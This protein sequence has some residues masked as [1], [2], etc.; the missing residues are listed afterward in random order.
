MANQPLFFP[1]GGTHHGSCFLARHGEVLQIP[2]PPVPPAVPRHLQDSAGEPVPTSALTL[3]CQPD[4]VS[5]SGSLLWP[6]QGWVAAVARGVGVV[7]GR[8]PHVVP[9]PQGRAV[10]LPALFDGLI[11]MFLYLWERVY[12]QKRDLHY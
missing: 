3:G 1:G 6:Q 7:V 12:F 8:V 11:R 2:L 10:C 9:S 4:G 5:K